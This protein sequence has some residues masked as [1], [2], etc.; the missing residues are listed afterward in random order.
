VD[1]YKNLRSM[2]LEASDHLVE[3]W[4]G[5]LPDSTLNQLSKLDLGSQSIQIV[6]YYNLIYRPRYIQNGYGKSA[7]SIISSLD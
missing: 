5:R 2:Y 7:Q 3:E 1:R 4:W 6:I